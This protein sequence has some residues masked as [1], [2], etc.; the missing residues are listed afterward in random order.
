ME[1]SGTFQEFDL[2]QALTSWPSLEEIS[3]VGNN[4][5]SI[6]LDVDAEAVKVGQVDK[7]C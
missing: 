7:Q 5:T 4:I 1:Y 6:V 3:V 2:T